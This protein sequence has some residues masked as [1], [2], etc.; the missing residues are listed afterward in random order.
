MQGHHRSLNESIMKSVKPYKTE[1]N[2]LTYLTAVMMV[3]NY[4][5]EMSVIV[6]KLAIFF[7]L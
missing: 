3:I 1:T 6:V 7:I 4:F 2:V 5:T